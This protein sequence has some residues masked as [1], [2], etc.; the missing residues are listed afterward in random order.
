M[1][2]QQEIASLYTIQTTGSPSTDEVPEDYLRTIEEKIYNKRHIDDRIQNIVINKDYA[3]LFLHKYHKVKKIELSL[4]EGENVRDTHSKNFEQTYFLFHDTILSKTSKEEPA[5]S[6][7]EIQLTQLQNLTIIFC[8]NNSYVLPIIFP[9]F[10][11]LHILKDQFP[12]T[13]LQ[14]L[15]N[16][17]II[18]FDKFFQKVKKKVKKI[19]VQSDTSYRL[20]LNH[21][22]K[23]S[24]LKSN[25]ETCLDSQ[26]I[27]NKPILKFVNEQKRAFAKNAAIVNCCCSISH[28]IEEAKLEADELSKYITEVD[29]QLNRLYQTRLTS[30][31]GIFVTL[32][33]FTSIFI[34]GL[35]KDIYNDSAS[36]G[37]I[38]AFILLVIFCG[39]CFLILILLYWHISLL[40]F[41]PLNR[42]TDEKNNKDASN[43]RDLEIVYS[44]FEQGHN[45]NSS[46]VRTNPENV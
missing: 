11:R 29:K 6:G 21:F 24:F 17:N 22:K 41:L 46:S 40:W 12:Y 28:S 9:N 39:I 43:T 1:P 8:E 2:E 3:V 32:I 45:S 18:S 34:S 25:F 33:V 38:I 26:K 14:S 36:T 30:F 37:I 23:L 27:A 16:D 31:R 44:E 42:N 4:L 15:V 5:K 35:F 19:E 10:M 7:T 20:N 13:I